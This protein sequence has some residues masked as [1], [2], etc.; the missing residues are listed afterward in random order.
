[1][2]TSNPD[3][4]PRTTPGLTPGGSVP[5]GTTPPAESGTSTGTG[6]HRPPKR[7][8][9]GG[10]L[11]VVVVLAVLVALFFLVYAIVVAL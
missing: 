6:P 8:W 2:T 5:A 10:P 7:G 3:P 1:M 11:T 9:A 4:D